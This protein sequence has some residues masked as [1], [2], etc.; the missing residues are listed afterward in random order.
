M[1]KPALSLTKTCLR[2]GVA[3]LLVL[4]ISTVQAEQ[5]RK[6]LIVLDPGHTSVDGGALSCR[7]VKEVNYND[8][9]T[10]L[11]RQQ[12]EAKGYSTILTRKPAEEIELK[13]RIEKANAVNADLFVSIHHDSA[14]PKYLQAFD[15]Q[16][17]P[18]F[19]AL[20]QLRDKFGLGFSIMVSRENPHYE[21]S[22]RLAKLVATNLE[23]Q[24]R[25]VSTH[26]AEGP[27]GENLEFADRKMGIYNY[28]GLAALRR[29]KM[30]AVLIEAGVIVD[31]IDEATINDPKQKMAIAKAITEAVAAYF[32]SNTK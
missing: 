20:K 12:L 4:C 22:F 2:V 11:V 25:T 3:A 16:G 18:A 15:F 31:E 23:A 6:L 7:G 5:A 32:K 14:Y 10:M 30:P 27:T 13:G 28:D 24:G 17:Q 21:E 1:V 8:A 29:T 19:R 26:H 9:L